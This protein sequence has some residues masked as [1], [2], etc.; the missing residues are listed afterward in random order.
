MTDDTTNPRPTP[1]PSTPPPPESPAPDT[2][3]TQV[4]GQ[5]EPTSELPSLE[6]PERTED[7]EA[8]EAPEPSEAAP[9]L[10]PSPATVP[11]T[12][13]APVAPTAPAS[14]V[15]TAPGGLVTVRTGPR[16][17]A[18]LLGLLCLLV[19]AYTTARQ[20]LDWRLD[21]NLVG[22]VTIGAMGALLLLV[23]LI[24]LVGRR[25]S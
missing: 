20:T 2:E 21:L 14:P 4:L 6:I 13:M 25:R 10:V 17:G 11:A 8:I 1:D 19:S 7:H 9:A 12:P 18:I 3:S 22:P 15:A 24:G 16:P 5:A 23:G